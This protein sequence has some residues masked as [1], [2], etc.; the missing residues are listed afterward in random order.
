MGSWSM[1]IC[2]AGAG[3]PS[4]GPDTSSLVFM[5]IALGLAVLAACL[6]VA[7]GVVLEM[8]SRR[9]SSRTLAAVGAIRAL[10][11]LPAGATVEIQLDGTKREFVVKNRLAS[12]GPDIPA[13]PATAGDELSRSGA[14]TPLDARRDRGVSARPL[15]GMNPSRGEQARP[16][17]SRH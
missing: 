7:G 9:R 8:L 6:W 14:G 17:S 15:T 16:M 13:S 10:T 3:F 11:P 5:N 1:A 12:H 4:G 2:S